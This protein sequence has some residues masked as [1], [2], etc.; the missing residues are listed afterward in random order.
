MKSPND[1]EFED[2]TEEVDAF[3]AAAIQQMFKEGANFQEIA[4]RLNMDVPAI[5]HRLRG[6]GDS[7]R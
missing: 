2:I 7:S 5:E 3:I 1:R 4:L 6:R